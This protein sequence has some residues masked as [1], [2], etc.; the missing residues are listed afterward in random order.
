MKNIGALA[1]A[2][3]ILF[4]SFGGSFWG[5]SFAAQARTPLSGDDVRH[6]IAAMKPL[7]KL[8]R[9][10]DFEDTGKQTV[11]GLNVMDFYPMSRSLDRVKNHKSFGEFKEIIHKVGFSSPEKWASIGDRV[12]RAY[13]FGRL[14]EGLSPEKLQD[15]QEKMAE[16]EK[17]VYLSPEI[18]KKILDNLKQTMAMAHKMPE[19]IKADQESLKPFLA[20]L[21][22]LFEEQ[23]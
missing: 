19:N 16:I 1:I 12:M 6:F 7:Q 13:M 22:R 2:V 11:E 4:G 3:L 23:E 14:V 21:K 18:R 9:K 15:M 17:N 5:S 10:Y 8:G 20:K